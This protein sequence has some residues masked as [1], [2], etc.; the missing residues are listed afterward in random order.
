MLF[1]VI[2]GCYVP[3]ECVF[4]HSSLWLPICCTQV[5]HIYCLDPM[6]YSILILP[7]YMTSSSLIDLRC[8]QPVL[9]E[10]KTHNK[11]VINYIIQCKTTV[12]IL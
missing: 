7:Y 8:L 9:F 10:T 5:S 1:Y 4:V 3:L 2:V 11:L 12:H 6:V